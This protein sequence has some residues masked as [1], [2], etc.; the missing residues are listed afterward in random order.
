MIQLLSHLVCSDF[1]NGSVLFEQCVVY[2]SILDLFVNKNP[3]PITI[4]T[5]R[6]LLKLAIPSLLDRHFDYEL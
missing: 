1:D 3:M 5:S 4:A 2:K 6:L